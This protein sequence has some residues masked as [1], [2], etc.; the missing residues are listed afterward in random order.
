MVARGCA[1]PDDR[2]AYDA[3]Q[4]RA[5][6]EIVGWLAEHYTARAGDPHRHPHLQINARVQAA[7]RWR[8]LHTV[9]VRDSLDATNGVGHAAV[10]TDPEFRATLAAHGYHLDPESA[11]I[12]ELAGYAGS[13]SARARQIEQNIDRYE[14]E[15]RTDH[16][17]QEPGPTIRR[18]W[19]RRAWADARPDGDELAAT[20][21]EE[22]HLFGFR[23]PSLPTE[24]ETTSIGSLGRDAAVRETLSR[25]GARRSARNA[26]DIRGEVEQLIA[27]AGVV[28]AAP[29]RRELAEHLT[30][31]VV[32]AST[33]LLERPDVP[34]HVRVPTSPRVLEVEREIVAR[35][36]H[37]AGG[38][39]FPAYVR[40]LRGHLSGLDDDQRVAVA[41]LTGG[42]ASDR[43]TPG[44]IRT[45]CAV[46]RPAWRSRPEPTSR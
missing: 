30:A 26:A 41:H 31:M 32:S 17:G 34:G 25:L 12:V 39:A 15:W 37:R 42:Q 44:C 14:A 20:W 33:Q 8:G 9:G 35:M 21:V 5:A 19:D 27:R 4:D 24:I 2:R 7:G 23:P 10:M 1:A 13:F 40:E 29:V 22:L 36:S 45:S 11:E 28:T 18:A 43:P 38:D 46:P 16:P 3:A 6:L